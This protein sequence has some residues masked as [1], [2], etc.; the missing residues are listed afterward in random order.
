MGL[1]DP[2]VL[3]DGLLLPAWLQGTALLLGLLLW[4]LGG[5]GHRFWI[6][7]LTTLLSGIVG[8]IWT[9][10]VVNTG[11]PI[12]RVAQL[13]GDRAQSLEEHDAEIGLGPFLPVRITH[14]REIEQ[15]LPE[16]QEVL[17]EVVDR[18][19]VGSE[20]RARHGGRLAVEV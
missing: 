16:T 3:E 5:W 12:L 9:H 13:V 1:V 17:G 2:K 6:V 18:R 4:L 7:L 19:R 10:K 20:R 15:R 11:D 14:G 8:L